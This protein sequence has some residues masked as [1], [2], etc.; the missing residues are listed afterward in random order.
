MLVYTSDV[1]YNCVVVSINTNFVL[2]GIRV[3]FLYSVLFII[4][5]IIFIVHI[6]FLGYAVFCWSI[7]IFVYTHLICYI[8]NNM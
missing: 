5:V 8:K 2:I 1:V 3:V 4:I 6:I 7:R